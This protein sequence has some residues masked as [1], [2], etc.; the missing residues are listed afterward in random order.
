MF[1]VEFQVNDVFEMDEQRH[2]VLALPVD[3][4]VLF[5]MDERLAEPVIHQRAQLENLVD[6]EELTRL[7]DPYAEHIANAAYATAKDIE[8]RDRRYKVI[9]NIVE[10]TE[11]FL[12]CRRRELFREAKLE[13]SKKSKFVGD[14]CRIFW[15]KGAVP[16]ALFG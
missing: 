12:R 6:E 9:K 10:D 3:H 8:V 13:H 4:V 15:R 5:N 2:R 14:I 11:F 1:Q 16:N 7:Q